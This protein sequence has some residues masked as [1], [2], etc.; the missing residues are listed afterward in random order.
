MKVERLDDLPLLGAALKE[1]KIA[2][3]IDKYFVAHG[4]WRG[5]SL[6]TVG[7]AFLLYVLSESDHRLSHIQEWA[8]RREFS[9]RHILDCPTFTHLDCTDDRLAALLDYF[10]H[11]TRY[12]EF[13]TALNQ[14]T[15]SVYSLAPI[16]DDLSSKVVHLD[17][18]IAQQY[19]DTTNL[20]TMGYAKHRRAD[21]PQIKVMLSTVGAL[22]LPLC[23]EVVTG[24]TADDVLYLPMIARVEETLKTK[25]L[26]FVGDSKLGSILNRL[27]IQ[28]GGNYYLTPLSRVQLPLSDLQAIV[29]DNNKNKVT[30]FNTFKTSEGDDV[31]LTAF[32]ITVDR[33]HE[34]TVWPERIIV[35]Y[36]EPYNNAQTAQFDKKLDKTA[37]DLSELT[38]AKQGKTP[39]K[40]V[41]EVQAKIDQTLKEFKTTDF[42]EVIIHTEYTTVTKRKYKDTPAQT[43]TNTSFSLTISRK[44]DKIDAHKAILGWRAYATNAPQ[45]QLSTEKVVAT[46]KD[47]FKV[48]Y[49]FNQL[50]NKT[51]PLMPI[52]LH[53]DNRIVA[54][55]RLLM[56]GIKVLGLLEYTIRKQIAAENITITQ[57]FPGNPGRKTEKPTAEMVLRAFH[58]ISLVIIAL[59]GFN[60]SHFHIEITE[61]SNSQQLLLRLAGFKN[62]IY[63]DIPQ[64][65]ISTLKISET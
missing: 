28:K 17:A 22:G 49:R 24:S 60:N 63:H 10:S 20:F 5:A 12:R 41:E 11:D 25:G 34:E 44:T 8:A 18:T 13:E 39:L 64:F 62:L 47:E 16:E 19:T 36:S 38:V 59:N 32:E 6:G 58:N 4:N 65:L 1:L 27:T 30:D 29:L 56:L 9:L 3:T 43:V 55:I 57:I 40:T 45:A 46:Y 61:L 53:K 2:E 48:E 21:L 15:L 42:F 7:S 51:A 50:H 31:E 33:T 52:F 37:A 14:H 26:L 35:A 54:L 23:V